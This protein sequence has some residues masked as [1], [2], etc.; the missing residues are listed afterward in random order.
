MKSYLQILQNHEIENNSF[1]LLADYFVN[2]KSPLTK[3]FCEGERYLP[4]FIL[5]K[6]LHAKFKPICRSDSE[7]NDLFMNAIIC[8]KIFYAG[9]ID[10]VKR[11]K[12]NLADFDQNFEKDI[13]PLGQSLINLLVSI[14]YRIMLANIYSEKLE[15]RKK[16][17]YAISKKIYS[18]IYNLLYKVSLIIGAH[19][20][21]GRKL[22]YI[23]TISVISLFWILN[24]IF[25]HNL[26]PIVSTVINI[27][28]GTLILLLSVVN[29]PLWDFGKIDISGKN[30]VSYKYRL[31]FNNKTKT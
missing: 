31:F 12:S 9:I 24:F 14:R 18:R 15:A 4:S 1:D 28:A 8:S 5:L 20:G 6:Q 7:L 21:L 25:L 13:E 3:E 19:N 23:L 26:Y 10:L 17:L 29:Y 30:I 27:I 11:S 22:Y 2:K 16:G